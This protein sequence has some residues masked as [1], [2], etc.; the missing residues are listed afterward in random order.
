VRIGIFGGTFDPVHHA[1]LIIADFVRLEAKLD[2][3]IFVPSAISPH[4][5]GEEVAVAADRLAMLQA[6]I[7]QSTVFEVSD[8]EIK[9]GGVSYSVDTVRELAG[10]HPKDQLFLMIGSDNLAEF[11]T[12]KDPDEILKRAELIAF[13]RPGHE[14]N[15]SEVPIGK[16]AIICDIPGIDISSTQVR[17]RVAAG[18]PIGLMVPEGVEKYIIEHGLYKRKTKTQLTFSTK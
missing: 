18:L 2:R 3:V 5:Q 15:P 10:E 1:H 13:K 4:K 12:W 8:M 9:R 7:G 6:A 16:E 11:S 17:K 14:V